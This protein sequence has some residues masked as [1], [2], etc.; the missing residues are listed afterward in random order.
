MMIRVAKCRFGPITQFYEHGEWKSV[1][2]DAVE[3]P[4][5]LAGLDKSHSRDFK[6]S[7]VS[8]PLLA[9]HSS[10]GVTRGEL[11][12]Q[13]KELGVWSRHLVPIHLPR[14]GERG[15]VVFIPAFKTLPRDSGAINRYK[16][17]VRE[18]A[19][20]RMCFESDNDIEAVV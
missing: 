15:E 13:L 11:T 17:P 14:T 20:D 9:I 18:A 5:V 6:V 16:A 4:G 12:E 3:K 1:N 19:G 10:A 7:Y 8:D 2:T